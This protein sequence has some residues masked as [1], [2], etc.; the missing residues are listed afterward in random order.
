MLKQ[1][2]SKALDVHE[3]CRTLIALG[4]TDVGV[5]LCDEVITDEEW[6]TVTDSLAWN[7]YF[8]YHWR[9]AQEEIGQ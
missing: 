6:E 8:G 9:K 7:Q 1:K 4:Y 3:Y 2:N 5:A